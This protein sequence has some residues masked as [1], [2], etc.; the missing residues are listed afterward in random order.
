MPSLLLCSF[1]TMYVNSEY[2][3]SVHKQGGILSFVWNNLQQP[4]R[5]SSGS[6][7]QSQQSSKAPNYSGANNWSRSQQQQT[8]SSSSQSTRRL[9]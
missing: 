5:Q 8:S 2:Y 7:Q 1:P 4:A 3:N 6:W 9:G